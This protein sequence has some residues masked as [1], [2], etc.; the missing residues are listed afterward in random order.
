VGRNRGRARDILSLQPWN[1]LHAPA[2][3][4]DAADEIASGA[5]IYEG[6]REF[7]GKYLVAFKAWG[8]RFA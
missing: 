2:K 4:C 7:L 1:C 5:L 3:E 6:T 8:L